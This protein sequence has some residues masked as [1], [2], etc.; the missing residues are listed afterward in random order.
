MLISNYSNAPTNQFHHSS[1][2]QAFSFSLLFLAA[3]VLFHS[4]KGAL[5]IVGTVPSD[6]ASYTARVFDVQF[7][8][9]MQF[10]ST[11]RDTACVKV[12]RDIE[13]GEEITCFY[14]EDF[15]GD[16][17]SYC[18]CETCERQV[19][20]MPV[21]CCLLGVHG[22]VKAYYSALMPMVFNLW[23]VYFFLMGIATA[24]YLF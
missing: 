15:F 22:K 20:S 24:N 10:V 4:S 8:V 18:E 14:G 23:K 12:L 21:A 17:N 13:D 7:N 11:G 2:G 9:R 1:A 5:L 19:P 3:F 6:F 16:G